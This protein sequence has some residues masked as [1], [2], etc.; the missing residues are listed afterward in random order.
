MPGKPNLDELKVALAD[1]AAPEGVAALYEQA[2]SE[3]GALALWSSRPALNPTASDALAI[4]WSLRVEGNLKARRLADRIEEACRAA[5]QAAIRDTANS[6]KAPGFTPEGLINEIRRNANYRA[7]DFERVAS[8][9]PI[10]P[11]A[12]MRQ[13]REALQ[14]AEAF[15]T[16]MP[17]DRIGLLF[18][19]N[20]KAV[21]PDPDRLG[22]H[23]V[24]QGRR[25]GHWPTTSEIGSA[26]LARL[27][28]VKSG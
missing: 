10:D 14:E 11:A 2:F 20:G 7:A 8:E 22:D 23:A 25:L 21:Q 4:S 5:V 1:R 6:R 17:T 24:H 28:P 3:F 26:M 27:S 16:Q 18:L 12:I 9:A 13:L 19:E 15:V